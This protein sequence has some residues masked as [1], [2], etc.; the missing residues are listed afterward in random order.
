[1]TAEPDFDVAVVG[2][3]VSGAVTA[4]LLAQRGHSVVLVDR[5][6]TP[7][8]KNLSGGVLYG[9]VL[10]RVM[11]GFAQ[12]AP[13]QR[14]IVRNTV[15]FLTE[16][17]GVYLDMAS[18]RLDGNA[19]TV[20]RA[21][22]DAWLADQAESAGAY[23]MPGV[24]VDGVLRDDAGAVCGVVAGE[25]ELRARVV[26]A[27][28]GVNSFLARGAGLRTAPPQ[29]HLAVGVKAV[30]ALPA[31]RIEERFGL[32]G[33]EGVAYALVGDVTRGVG[34]GAFLY[35]N[36][37][38]LSVG[39]VLRLDDLVASGHGAADL[40]EHLCRHPEVARLLRGG[41]VVEYGSH[42]VAEGGL[43][44]LGSVVTDGMVVVGDAAGLT[45]NS[46][47]TVRGMDLAV[48]SAIAA[49]G[50]VHDALEAGD[51]TSTG[52][53]GYRTRLMSGT[54]GADLRTYAKAPAF[55]ERPRMYRGYADLLETMLTDVFDLDGT[56]RRP[57]RKVAAD[58]LR[59][60]PIRA[61]DLV[62]D[63][64]AGVRAL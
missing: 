17:G 47:L 41:E 9:R 25:D 33:D 54:V 48:G 16:S 3:G 39:V 42:L 13:V 31:E 11:P 27:A 21:G 52:L 10:D 58:A 5:G 12:R 32:T 38:S 29:H 1:V 7:G 61:R 8:S 14:R 15:G 20:L 60:S 19:V 24:R 56:P 30:V 28:D 18:P 44:M 34:G 64:V 37:D 49:A 45:I 26:V 23:L 62:S 53:A 43:A 2:A 36:T 59:R 46:G 40:F 51:T 4:F 50:G 6:E 55:L 22:F 63:A 35:T 57:M